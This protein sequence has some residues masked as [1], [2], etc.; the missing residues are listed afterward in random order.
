MYLDLNVSRRSENQ[1]YT[2]ELHANIIKNKE[3][4]YKELSLQIKKLTNFDTYLYKVDQVYN[5]Q[6]WNDIHQ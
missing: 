4:F 5:S 6:V 1:L 3:L 2:K